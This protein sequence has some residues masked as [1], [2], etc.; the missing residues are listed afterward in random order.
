MAL[1][2]RLI[3][4]PHAGE[5]QVS[6]YESFSRRIKIDREALDDAVQ[7]Q[8]E[9]FLRVCEFH[10]IATSQRDRMKADLDREDALIANK[11]RMTQMNSEVR[12]TD[13]M[14]KE[15]VATHPEHL[16]RVRELSEAD[17][18]SDRWWIL[19]SSFDMRA[20]ML[21]ELV[22]LYTSGYYGANTAAAPRGRV[23]D[24]LAEDARRRLADV[25][26]E[27]FSEKD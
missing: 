24:A 19:R 26:K 10:V 9:I 5:V 27:K 11:F 4:S 17:S 3:G 2:R 8:A 12:V 14:I 1:K 15:H 22:S 6:D 23:G 21:R 13:S 25:R 18:A 7:E 20:K 16:R